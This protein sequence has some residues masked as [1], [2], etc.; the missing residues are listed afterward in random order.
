MLGNEYPEEEPKTYP[1][2]IVKV[3][4]YQFYTF[5]LAILKWETDEAVTIFKNGKAKANGRAKGKKYLWSSVG[6]GDVFT[7]CR[8]S[9]PTACSKDVAFY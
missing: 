9:Q 7:I 3:D 6:K 5:R 2:T 1:V 8:Q 4:S